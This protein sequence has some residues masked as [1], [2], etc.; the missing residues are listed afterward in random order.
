MTDRLCRCQTDDVRLKIAQNSIMKPIDEPVDRQLAA[1][2]PGL[3]QKRGT[4]KVPNLEDHV[5]F[6]E[7]FHALGGIFD[8]FDLLTEGFKGFGDRGKPVVDEPNSISPERGLNPAT[9]VVS[10]NNDVEH[11][12]HIDGILHCRK[13]I[14]IG[15]GNDVGN[16]AMDKDF[17]R[18][19]TDDLIGRHATI[20]AAN[21]Q[22]FWNLLLGQ[23]FEESWL[24]LA[25]S[26][27]PAPIVFKERLQV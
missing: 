6:T 5:Y 21:P 4:T 23:I 12:E 18:L 22:E 13:T 16:V 20:R 17:A 11:L 14:E 26:E 7:L 8:G 27:R 15:Q 2:A 10:A 25:H 1:V 9:P 3:S 24:L 19:Q